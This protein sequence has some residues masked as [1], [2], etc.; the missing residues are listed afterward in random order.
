M[1]IKDKIF[2]QELR[3][4][5][6][7]K[8]VD[9]WN[10]KWQSD[11]DE[12]Q[13]F[14]EII[15]K[16][17]FLEAILVDIELCLFQKL[18]G[19]SSKYLFSKDFLR[20]FIYEYGSKDVRIQSHSRTSIALYL[21]YESWENF[22]SQNQI[23]DSQ[24]ISINYINI[25]ESFL[26]VFLKKQS[27]ILD[28]Q[29]FVD[30]KEIKPNFRKY[31]YG[32]LGLLI[33]LS[34]SFFG[35]RFWQDRDFT[36]K[37]LNNIKFEII[38][39]VG[40][41]PQAVRIKYDVS[42][43]PNVQDIEIE[44]GVGKIITTDIVE[45]YSYVSQK[46]TDTLSQT[47]FYPGIY[48][49]ALLVNKKVVKNI[50]HVVYSKPNLW[51]AWGYGVA[52]GKEWTTNIKPTN[53]F[54]KNGVFHF[55]SKHLYNEIKSEYDMNNSV[56]V[57][58]QDFGV[59]FDSTQFETRI[60]NPQSEGGESCY[61]MEIVF[62]DNNFNSIDAKFTA[63]GCTDFAI[64]LAGESYFRMQNAR[65]KNIDLDEFGV[66][67]DEWNVFGFLVKGKVLEVF[68]NHKL[69]F[70]GNF[71]TNEPFA[72]LVDARITFKGTG[73]IDWVKVSNSYTGKVVYQTDFDEKNLIADHLE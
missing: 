38:K 39:T 33:L 34:I 54:I 41:Y 3:E 25:D 5:F 11:F 65:Q 37:D 61:D 70:K 22:M 13:N 42:S 43:L 31:F 16:N 72:G 1:K 45:G 21:G 12:F 18:K 44:T 63:L 57:L 36:K 30:F 19:Q 14:E 55:D 73:S 56:H 7:Q 23:D 15:N 69:A 50:Y 27:L 24:N 2:L 35:C 29:S 32:F 49:L 8:L 40:T 71:I 9:E 20:R 53:L 52:Y 64:L 26:P 62:V 48:H 6:L 17:A 10:Q 60:K 46:K 68:V 66:N 4:Q 28:N 67:Q 58:T 51:T 59:N 47:Y